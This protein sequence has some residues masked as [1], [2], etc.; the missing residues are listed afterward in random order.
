MGRLFDGAAA[1][2]GIRKT[3]GYE[4]QGAVLLEAA[5]YDN[6][7]SLLPYD[8][9]E[10]NGLCL[11]DWRETVRA[12]AGA[13]K[14]GTETGLSAAQFMNTLIDMAVHQCKAVREQTDLKRVVL[15]GGCFQNL[16]LLRRLPEKLEKAGFEVYRHRQTACNDEGLA[17]GQ[18]AIAEAGWRKYVPGSALKTD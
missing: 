8:M 7:E 18:A 12:L 16:Y 14:N 15:S 3:A 2:L 6:E 9:K 11:F 13:V 1:I 10:E 5:A 4:G 17:L